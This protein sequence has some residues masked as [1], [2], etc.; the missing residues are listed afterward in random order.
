[1]MALR[2]LKQFR[3]SCQDMDTLFGMTANTTRTSK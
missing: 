2:A 3:F 1:M